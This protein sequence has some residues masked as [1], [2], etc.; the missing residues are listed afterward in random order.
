MYPCSK[1]YGNL[2][3]I[4]ITRIDATLFLGE[5]LAPEKALNNTSLVLLTN[6]VRFICFC[7]EI[8][9]GMSLSN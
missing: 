8:L 9:L 2:L 7:K 3:T 4:V 6:F 5:L 1:Y